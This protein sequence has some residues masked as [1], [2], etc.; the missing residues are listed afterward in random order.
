[1]WLSGRLSFTNAL[2]I[3]AAVTIPVLLMTIALCIRLPSSDEVKTVGTGGQE[4]KTRDMTRRQA[5]ASAH[6]WTIAGPLMLAIMVQVGFIVHQVSFLF[7]ILG[8]EGAGSR[9]F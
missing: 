6:Y 9:Y 7:P 5:L 2:E 8:R 1:V 3:I 4:A